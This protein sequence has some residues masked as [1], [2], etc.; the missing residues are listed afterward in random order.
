M[1]SVS[2][3]NDLVLVRQWVTRMTHLL[4]IVSEKQDDVER[5]SIERHYAIAQNR[6]REATRLLMLIQ[7]ED[8]TAA[9]IRASLY[10]WLKVT[11]M[12][13]A[14]E[15][16]TEVRVRLVAAYEMYEAWKMV[17]AR[18][19]S[20]L[21]GAE[22]TDAVDR[23]GAAFDIQSMATIRALPDSLEVLTL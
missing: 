13:A 17:E 7:R 4:E 14:F 5:L 6:K 1:A 15:Q 9:L 19:P 16:V 23:A 10:T 20:G 12:S 8:A 22:W 11:S 3:L 21:P 2:R 18:G